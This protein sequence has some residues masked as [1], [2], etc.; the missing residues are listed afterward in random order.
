MPAGVA[1]VIPAKDETELIG[2]TVLAAREILGVD[3]IIVVD[4]G[5]SDR[6]AATARAAGAAVVSHR[7]NRGKAAAMAT[8]AQAVALLDAARAQTVRESAAQPPAARGLLF[9]DADLA[10]SACGAAGLV[11]LV[12]A[13]HADM[14]IAILPSQHAPGGGRGRVVDLARQGIITATGW[15]PTQPLS[16]IRCLSR[17]AFD[18]ASPLAAG[19]G[20][21]TALTIDL[22]RAGMR[23]REVPCEL[24]HR[25]SGAD[26]AGTLHRAAQYRD[27]ARALAARGLLDLGLR[28]LLRPVPRSC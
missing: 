28:R 16:G 11:D 12:L 19:W 21:E 13:G 18:A 17:A 6:T 27:V 10:E 1:V 4:D 15:L 5:S 8:G 9:L 3:V 20:V 26:L 14:T 7:R 22:L 25:V 24:F 2:R 23:V